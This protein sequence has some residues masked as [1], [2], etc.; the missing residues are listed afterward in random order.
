MADSVTM[1]TVSGVTG[2]G[3]A[4]VRLMQNDQ[5]LMQVRPADARALGQ[6]L[7]NSADAAEQDAFVMA[8]FCNTYRQTREHA[9]NAVIALRKFR[10][11]RRNEGKLIV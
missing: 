9:M 6:A 11:A 10:D 7:F 3:D 1:Y 2:D 5:M 4:F 8:F